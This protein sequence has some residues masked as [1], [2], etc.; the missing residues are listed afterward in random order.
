MNWNRAEELLERYYEGQSSTQEEQELKELL[1][2]PNLPPHLQKEG[3]LL[4][5][6]QDA[7]KE[8][9][10]LPDDALF[11]RLDQQLA[12][13]KPK[14]KTIQLPVKTLWQIAAAVALLLVGYGLGSMQKTAPQAQVANTS[15]PTE[16][17][18]EIQKEVAEMKTLLSQNSPSQRLKAVNYV[19]E[20][21][22]ADEELIQV[23]I[24]T[25]HFDENVNVRIAAVKALLHFQDRP[26]V[27]KALIQSLQIQSDPNVQL[28]LIDVLVEMNEK[29]AIPQMQ[30]L[31][32]NK[33]LQ[34]VVRKRLQQGIGTLI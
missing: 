21:G 14:A 10:M 28:Q 13:E 1:S 11:S 9:T 26:Q 31:L 12:Q 7:G 34:E 27:R 25:M 17:L 5:H 20:I 18:A 3:A 19:Q 22:G 23:L 6:L 32:L 8:E 15:S 30:E 2:R 29:E 24:Q 33:E 16:Q 4:N